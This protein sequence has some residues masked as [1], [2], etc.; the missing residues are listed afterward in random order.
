MYA[1]SG[2]L[3]ALYAREHSGAGASLRVS[4]FD[5][6]AEWMGYPSYYTRYGGTAP[7]R[8][9]LSHPAIAPYGPFTAAAGEQIVFSVQN[10]GEWRSMCREV[11]RD[12][13]VAK[14]PRFLTNNDRVAHRDALDGRLQECFATL[15][16]DELLARLGTARIAVGRL[17]TV[18]QFL[19]HPAILER[20]RLRSVGSPVGE[21][22]AVKPP[23]DW[24]G[25]EPR[26]GD[27]PAL[28]A[29]TDAVRAEF[30]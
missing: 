24:A 23:I 10:D 9:G 2:I 29:H 16:V 27:I 26:M 19:E 6:L 3:A 21:L 4:L 5:A 15:P 28:G 7:A 12:E 14:D 22:T 13:T 25:V 17:R 18:E 11:L 20:D 30:S 1:F 8:A